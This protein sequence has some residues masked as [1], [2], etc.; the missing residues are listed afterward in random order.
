MIIVQVIYDVL[1]YVFWDCVWSACTKKAIFRRIY[2]RVKALFNKN[3]E[4]GA[5]DSNMVDVLL[6][7]SLYYFDCSRMHI[8]SRHAGSNLQISPF[9][10]TAGL[11]CNL[12]LSTTIL[13][14]D[15]DTVTAI[16]RK[17]KT[18]HG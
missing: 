14:S 17:Y 8:Y 13:T 7:F 1:S 4:S 10:G 3:F 9:G 12:H 16:A 2:S 18:R 15:Y 6:F 5:A 11:L